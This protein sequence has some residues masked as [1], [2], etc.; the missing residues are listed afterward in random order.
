MTSFS[1][2]P[3][4][5]RKAS[6]RTSSGTSCA[7]APG[8]KASSRLRTTSPRGTAAVRAKRPSIADF[9]YTEDVTRGGGAMSKRKIVGGIFVGLLV[10]LGCTQGLLQQQANQA[11]QGELVSAPAFEV[12][13]L[14]PKPL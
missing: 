5:F 14:W 10:L 4:G 7:R 9:A 2:W 13:P 6:T 1:A 11:N 12:D 8:A 3:S